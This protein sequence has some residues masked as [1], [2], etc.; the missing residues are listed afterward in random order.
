MKVCFKVVRTDTWYPEYEVPDG[1][2]DEEVLDYI[3][4]ESPASVFDEMYNKYTLD[5]DLDI[6]VVEVVG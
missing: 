4:N 5:T 3:N 6:D 1:L 2:T